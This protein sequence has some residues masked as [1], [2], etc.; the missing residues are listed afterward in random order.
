MCHDVGFADIQFEI[1]HVEEFPLDPTDIALAE[2]TCAHRPVHV[3]ERRVIQVLRRM[4]Q[5][6][7][8]TFIPKAVYKKCLPCSRR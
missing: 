8:R 3:L 4:G 1:E 6:E 5:H 2:D 7:S